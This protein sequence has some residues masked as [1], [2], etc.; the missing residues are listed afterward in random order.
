MNP[1]NNKWCLSTNNEEYDYDFFDTKEE[2]IAYANS[3][4]DYNECETMFVGKA[5]YYEPYV[6]AHKFQRFEVYFFRHNFRFSKIMGC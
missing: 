6:D 3:C 4:D 5:E 2:A 1:N